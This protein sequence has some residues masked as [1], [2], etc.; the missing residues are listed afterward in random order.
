MKW[1]TLTALV[2]SCLIALAAY[3]YPW[4]RPVEASLASLKLTQL[5]ISDLQVGVESVSRVH[6]PDSEEWRR[7]IA[8]W[9][10]PDL[11]AAVESGLGKPEIVCFPETQLKIKVTDVVGRIVAATSTGAAPYGYTSQCATTGLEFRASAGSEL[12][13]H[14]TRLGGR[15]QTTG[16]LVVMPYWR[17]EKDRLVGDMLAPDLKRVAIGLG[18]VGLCCLAA[19]VWLYYRQVATH[20]TA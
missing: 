20:R 16:E 15:D 2:G 11:I 14:V 10:S 4:A 18:V 13:L 6:V 19:C 5:P 17:F 1:I 9:G 7:L 12:L 3:V 8:E